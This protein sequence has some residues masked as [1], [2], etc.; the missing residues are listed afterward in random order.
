MFSKEERFPRPHFLKNKFV[1]ELGTAGD[2]AVAYQ[3]VRNDAGLGSP[4][5]YKANP[6]HASFV[7]VEG[8]GCYEN[9][10]IFSGSM[11]LD[12][13]ITKAC[14]VTDKIFELNFAIIPYVFSFKEDYTAID[15][16]SSLEVQDLLFQ[17]T[18]AVDEQGGPL[19]NGRDVSG[20]IINLDS[21]AP[22][23]TTDAKLEY[24]GMEETNMEN[25]YKML[26]YGSPKLT[27][28]LKSCMPQGVKWYHVGRGQTK[29]INIK[30]SSKIK[31]I[32]EYSNCGVII[33]LPMSDDMHQRT[34]A[35]DAGVGTYHLLASV[36][37][38]Y[39]E[40]HPDF[41]FMRI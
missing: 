20:D 11:N 7:E 6:E 16:L 33:Y 14:H 23:L 19:Y 26:Q 38:R 36:Y 29:H 34:L 31:A 13:S 18:E 12:L 28:K 1:L 40:W 25:I 15:E 39:N 10:K 3:F 8:C 37:G 32:D 2:H 21:T 9:S 5:S 41:D 27:G 17:Q 30:F 4:A 22:F 24:I 35:A